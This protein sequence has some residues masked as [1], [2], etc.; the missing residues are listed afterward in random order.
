VASCR[1]HGRVHQRPNGATHHDGY[2]EDRSLCCLASM[3]NHRQRRRSSRR[4]R[5][6][7]S[8]LSNDRPLCH[9]QRR[10]GLRWPADTLR[11]NT[12]AST[13]NQPPRSIPH[14]LSACPRF[15]CMG[16]FLSRTLAY[17]R[18]FFFRRFLCLIR[19]P[20]SLS[21]PALAH[22]GARRRCQGWASYRPC[23]MLRLASPHLD[24]VE[25]DGTLRRSG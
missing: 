9:P 20:V 25:H 11:P 3:V 2:E 6:S 8:T 4:S 13:A 7:N 18:I 5:S 24:G 1:K 22:V 21:R 10:N 16:L 23:G 14:S 19:D 15:P 17:R 12:A